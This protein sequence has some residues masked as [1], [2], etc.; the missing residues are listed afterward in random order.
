MDDGVV[1]IHRPCEVE[2]P[3]RPVKIARL[4]TNPAIRALN[5]RIVGIERQCF[6]RQS[7]GPTAS[8]RPTASGPRRWS[9]WSGRDV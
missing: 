3:F 7:P 8:L 2:V 1:R 5:A 9:A 4:G 6:L